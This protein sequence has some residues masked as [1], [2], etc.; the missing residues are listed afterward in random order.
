MRHSRTAWC[1]LAIGITLSA[2]LAAQDPASQSGAPNTA[3]S[4]TIPP[5]TFTV[6]VVATT[7]L[8]DVT[9]PIE[10]IAAPVQ[11]LSGEAIDNSGALDLSSYLN[12]RLNGVHVN[13]VQNNPLQ[14]D[15]SYRGY[16]ASSLLGTPQ[17][18]SVYMDGVR[19]NQPFGEVVSWDLI[20]R[21]AIFSGALMPGSNPLFGLN[22]LGGALSIQT[23]DGRNSPG[24]TV[25][26]MYGSDVRRSLEF[27]HGGS[28]SS[29]GIDW[30]ADR[31]PLLRRWLAGRLSVRRGPTVRQ[32]RLAEKPRGRLRHA[33]LQRQLAQR[34]RTPGV[35]L[36]GTRLLERLHQ[37]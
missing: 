19:L 21:M 11:T 7:P 28:Q 17:G 4:Q 36:P 6:T 35:R 8:A 31:E 1:A 34:Q 10:E 3:P 26:V 15:V 24:T 12:R 18:L 30:Y 2:P 37:A 5:T 20:P 9:I 32:A 29:N 23:K 16:T 13:E 33:R 27:E 25:Q 14:P 22:T